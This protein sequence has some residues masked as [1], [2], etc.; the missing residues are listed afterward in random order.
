MSML[1]LFV[2]PHLTRKRFLG[3]TPVPLTQTFFFQRYFRRAHVAQSLA[4]RTGTGRWFD[5]LLG[6]YSF[7]G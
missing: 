7:M 6:Q 2:S 4:Y 1:P 3:H 5:P